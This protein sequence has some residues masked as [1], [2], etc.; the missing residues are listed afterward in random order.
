MINKNLLLFFNFQGNFGLL[1]TWNLNISLPI[2][3]NHDSG[4]INCPLIL[5]AHDEAEFVLVFFLYFI[6]Q[7]IIK[8]WQI[9]KSSISAIL[10]K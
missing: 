4:H 3:F 8:K 6:S 2:L 1:D 5:L 7:I 10:D 9:D